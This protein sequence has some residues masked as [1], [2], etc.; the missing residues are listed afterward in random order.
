MASDCT[1][2]LFLSVANCTT[3]V[4][5][6]RRMADMINKVDGDIALVQLD[7]LAT[8]IG[9]G[10]IRCLF[11]QMGGVVALVFIWARGWMRGWMR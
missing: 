11:A 8:W 5:M 9:V 4:G 7:R 10:L 2:V 1:N 3:T 6:F